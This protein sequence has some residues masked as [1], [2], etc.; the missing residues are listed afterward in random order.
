LSSQEPFDVVSMDLTI[1]GGMGGVETV[2]ELL[3]KDPNLMAI[4]SSGYANDSILSDFAKYGFKGGIAKPFNIPELSNLI[5]KV[6]A[7]KKPPA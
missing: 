6:M 5:D 3:K 2:S 1:P 7:E 4:V